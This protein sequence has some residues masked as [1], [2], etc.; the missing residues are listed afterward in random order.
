MAIRQQSRLRKGRGATYDP[1]NR[2]AATASE[3]VD[4]GWWQEVWPDRLVRAR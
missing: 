2:F 4:D 3:A 1:H